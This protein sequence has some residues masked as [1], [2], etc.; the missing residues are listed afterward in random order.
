MLPANTAGCIS[1]LSGTKGSLAFLSTI[2]KIISDATPI[3]NGIANPIILSG[4]EPLLVIATRKDTN[5][6]AIVT[7][8]LMSTLILLAALGLSLEVFFLICSTS[9]ILAVSSI[10]R[11][12]QHKNN[13]IAAIGAQMKKMVCQPVAATKVGPNTTPKAIPPE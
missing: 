12:R 6:T 13:S 5:A 4:N 1:N 11:P 2:K 8:P 3:I 9:P 7:I 10:G